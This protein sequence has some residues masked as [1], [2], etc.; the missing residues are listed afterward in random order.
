MWSIIKIAILCV[1]AVFA[2]FGG[3]SYFFPPS[4]ETR[5][6]MGEP[7]RTCEQGSCIYQYNLVVGNTGTAAQPDVEIVFSEAT[8]KHLFQDLRPTHH[9][10]LRK[11]AKVR[12]LENSVRVQLGEM[13]PG[14]QVDIRF[15]L[16]LPI[17]QKPFGY[18]QLVVRIKPAQ[19]ELIEGH[20]NL[21]RIGRFLILT[22]LIW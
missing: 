7:F 17:S 5:Y 4:Y 8:A 1:A 10:L 14:R 11:K 2:L 12:E 13:E 20:P 19:G 16:L 15:K 21:T 18:D 3:A 6:T 22:F 9:G